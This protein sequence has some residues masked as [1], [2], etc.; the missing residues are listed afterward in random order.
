MT[1]RLL[2]LSLCFIS[3]IKIQAQDVHRTACDGDL[4]KLDSMLQYTDI[5]ILDDRGRTLLHWAAACKQVKVMD[6]IIDRGVKI[7][8]IDNDG[9]SALYYAFSFQRDSLIDQMIAIQPTNE[10]VTIEGAKLIQNSIL[11]GNMKQVQ[12]LIENGVDIEIENERGTRPLELAKRVDATEIYDWLQTQGADVS[13]IRS[14]TA[15][16]P[17][18]GQENPGLTKQVFAPNFISTEEFEYGSVFNKEATEFYY[19]IAKNDYPV[20][21]FTR[22]IDGVW[23]EPVTILSDEKYGYND[24]FLSPDE[25]RLYF[26]SERNM[27]GSDIKEDHDIWYVQKTD[28]GS[29]SEPINAGPNINSESNEYYIS[30]TNTGTMYFASN[31]NAP[32]ERKRSDQDIYYSPFVDGE[33]QEPVRLSDS[34]NTENYEADVF[35]DPDEEY[36]IYCSTRPEGLGRG[37]LYIS[38]KNEDGS[39]AQAQN[40]GEAVNSEH[41]ELCPYVTADGKYLLYTSNREIYWISTEVLDKYR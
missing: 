7:D 28:D 26:I 40:M 5:N 1:N 25:I 19:A 4:I 35:I 17:Y 31:V 22:L 27:D 33:F 12:T 20:I 8:H 10:W 41:H 13:K 3:F 11:N 24:P 32:E 23:S 18:F 6:E 30:F 14:F 21:R 9:N 38:F 37:D 36:I 15:S 16:G 39:W 34:I 2:L 29:W